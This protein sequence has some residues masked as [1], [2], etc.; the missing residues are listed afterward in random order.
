VWEKI[1]DGEGGQVGKLKKMREKE[2]K[3]IA[4]TKTRRKIKQ[5]TTPKMTRRKW[6]TRAHR[7]VHSQNLNTFG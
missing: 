2:R 6:L 4:N 5:A 7:H 3:E 1:G